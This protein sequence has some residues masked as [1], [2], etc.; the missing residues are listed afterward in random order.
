L[1][2]SVLASTPAVYR[3]AQHLLKDEADISSIYFEE[4][5]GKIKAVVNQK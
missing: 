2:A 1:W 5:G 4:H 3:L